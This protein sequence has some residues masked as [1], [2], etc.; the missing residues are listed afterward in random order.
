MLPNRKGVFPPRRG[1]GEGCYYITEV[2]FSEHNIVHKAIFY[3][4]FL[5]EGEPGAYNCIFNPTYDRNY[6]INEAYYLKVLHKIKG[7]GRK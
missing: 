2:A 1:W 7:I 3:T 4:G 6:R 5:N